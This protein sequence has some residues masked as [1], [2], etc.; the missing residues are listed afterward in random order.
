MSMNKYIAHRNETSG[1]VQTVK[2]H[3]ENTAALCRDY[4]VP[5]LKDFMYAV[6][7]LHDVGKFQESFVKRINGANIKVEHSAC[8]ACK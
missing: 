8:G 4:A 1:A 6:G 7:M 2:E 3:C 5:E